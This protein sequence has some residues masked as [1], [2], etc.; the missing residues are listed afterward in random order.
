MPQKLGWSPAIN[1]KERGHFS[2]GTV[3]NATA[4]E[5]IIDCTGIDTLSVQVVSGGTLAATITVR[6][7]N[8]Y[9]PG[10]ADVPFGAPQAG[11]PI[12]AGSFVDITS[13]C[14]GI[15]NP[16]GAGGDCIVTVGAAAEPN[17]PHN[18]VMIR[19][20]QSAGSGSLDMY[21][22]GKTLGGA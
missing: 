21:V 8:S 13:R 4:R 14:T 19:F 5:L 9:I 15:T 20:V 12:R 17:V 7:S 18:F 10:P 1:A 11:T 3:A 22:S 2:F 6:A 16:S